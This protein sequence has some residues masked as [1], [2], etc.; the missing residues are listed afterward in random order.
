MQRFAN[1]NK[2]ITHLCCDGKVKY[3]AN[4]YQS[5]YYIFT[6]TTV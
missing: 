5:I 4:E 3:V 2:I 6:F 1:D